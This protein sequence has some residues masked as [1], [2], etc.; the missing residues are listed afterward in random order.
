MAL[1]ADWLIVSA[2]LKTKKE[3]QL[4]SLLQNFK[5]AACH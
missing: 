5:N 2:Q 1:S 4:G 3:S